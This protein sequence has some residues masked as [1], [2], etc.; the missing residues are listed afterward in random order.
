MLKSAS[1]QQ[2]SGEVVVLLLMLVIVAVV[3]TTRYRVTLD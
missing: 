1:V 2:I 3:A